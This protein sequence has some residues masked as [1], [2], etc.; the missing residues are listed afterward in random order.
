MQLFPCPFC[1]D[2]DESEFLFLG[3]AGKV[4]PSGGR[5]VSDADWEA[6]LHLR[7][8]KAGREAGIWRHMP[9]GEVFLMERDTL[10]H[11]VLSHRSLRPEGGR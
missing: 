2:R 10:S 1:G 4:R 8:P 3:E 5:D 7:S 11:A 6:Y 9:C